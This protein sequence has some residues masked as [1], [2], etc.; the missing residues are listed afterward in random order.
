MIADD[1]TGVSSCLAGMLENIGHSVV[2]CVCSGAEALEKTI[3]LSPDLVIMDI[4]MGDMDGL[5]A[6][7]RIL[8]KRP[9]PI[10]I[11]SAYCE[12]NLIKEADDI[13]VAGYLVKPF[14]LNGL[15][16]ALALAWSRFQQI[17]ALKKQIGD[18]QETLKSRKLIEKAKGLLM[19]REGITEA[20][21]FRRIQGMSRNQNIAMNRLAEAI[22]ISEKLMGP[23]HERTRPPIS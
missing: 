23:K 18:I 2:A 7:K 12:P 11:L 13:G 21:A 3:S 22:I 6:S 20:A 5:E 15:Q 14:S 4:K 17:L 19:E 9:L 16:P 10:V 1:D 8:E